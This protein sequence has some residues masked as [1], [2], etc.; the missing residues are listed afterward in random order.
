[1]SFSRLTHAL[2]QQ[3]GS[4][5]SNPLISPRAAMIFV[6]VG[7]GSALAGT[8]IWSVAPK[9]QR[10]RAT[11][12]AVVVGLAL[13]G[14]AY[15]LTIRQWPWIARIDG[16][17]MAIAFGIGTFVTKVLLLGL[18]QLPQTIIDGAKTI[19]VASASR[20][21]NP[22]ASPAARPSSPNGDPEKPS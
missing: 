22:S 6:F 21:A 17:A 19:L 3:A 11:I 14:L 18:D 12:C 20:I 7:I 5:I 9:H 4:A 15:G 8:L 2:F 16:S 10:Q 13:G 1:M